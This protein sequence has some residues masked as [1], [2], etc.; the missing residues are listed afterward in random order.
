MDKPQSRTLTVG[1]LFSGG[2]G[3]A[4]GFRQAGL[5]VLWGVD[6]WPPAVR[7]F[8]KNFPESAALERDILTLDFAELPRVDVLIGSPPCVQFSP[9]NR[10]GN[11]DKQLGMELV[12]SFLRA[13][14]KLKPRYWVME[15]VPALLPYLEARMEGDLYRDDRVEVRVPRRSVLNAAHFATPQVRRRLFSGRFTP[16]M[17]L[18]SSANGQ[19]PLQRVLDFI[20]DPAQKRPP[21]SCV[22][23]DPVYTGRFVHA[24]CL[25]DHFEDLRWRLTKI[26]VQSTMDRRSH[27]RIYGVMPFPD[28]LTRPSRTI[29][30]TKTRGSRATH[31]IPAPSAGSVGYRTLTVRECASA[32]GFP[33][34][35]QFWSDSLS[36]KDALVG[37]AVP[38]PLARAIGRSI[39][40]DAGLTPPTRPNLF[41]AEELAPVVRTRRHASR[42]FS[43]KRRF[44][45]A[46]DID[47]RRDHRVELDNE[48]PRIVRS[49]PTDTLPP[50]T[51]RARMYLGY[52]RDYRCYEPRLEDSLRLAESLVSAAQPRVR[53]G[54][55]RQLL[56]SI[57]A[58][59]RG[60][61]PSGMELQ[62]VWS[63]WKSAGVGPHDVCSLVTSEVNRAFPANE[64]A[65]S[66]LPKEVTS[67]IL[68]NRLVYRG[69]DADS[70]QPI[71][72]S[73]R[74]TI[75][76][77]CLAF[78]SESLNGGIKR[79]R[80]ALSRL[81]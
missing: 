75:G 32:Q 60:K 81:N 46:I 8:Q 12:S 28:D 47:W 24:A 67:E 22:I 3:F 51:W 17:E 5:R 19:I 18:H 65:E 4:E 40:V 2:G 70:Q 6:N 50:I 30:A 49:L 11:G 26:E 23:H 13:V 21:D 77:V 16:P 62:E 27:D 33:L 52:A 9:A 59:S 73:V 71:D 34:S 31:V 78:V 20:P 14:A 48:L 42:H 61:I 79:A 76:A 72:T 1:D 41:I 36:G 58:L 44:R 80:T 38:P 63:G 74:L 56:R 10:G 45:G 37:N 15:N 7:T 39:M 64:W 35:F 68:A 53:R 25:R 43:M 57:V 54:D 69:V 29:T 55:L 66:V